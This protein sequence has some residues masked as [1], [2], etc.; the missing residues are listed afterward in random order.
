M[1]K[2]ILLACMFTLAVCG[3][4]GAG[5]KSV[6]A[7]GE[8]E[9]TLTF[10]AFNFRT[11]SYYTI[12]ADLKGAGD[13]FYVYVEHGWTVDPTDIQDIIN[14]FGII[15]TKLRD[16]YGEEKPDVN[17]DS[18]VYILLLDIQDD[19]NWPT[20]T[21]YTDGYFNP[22]DLY[23]NERY[24]NKRKVLYMDIH[25]GLYLTGFYSPK[26]PNPN[27]RNTMAHEFQHLIH[28]NI[29]PSD[30]TWLNEAMSEVASFYAFNEPRWNRVE[31]FQRNGNH[32][33]SLT[34]WDHELADYAVVYMW[35]QYMADRFPNDVFRNILAV[36]NLKGK[37]SVEE[38]LS[39]HSDPLGKKLEFASV[40]RDWSIAMF[41]GNNTSVFTDNAVW[42]YKSI[43][44]WPG[45]YN[46]VSIP[47]LFKSTNLNQAGFLSLDPWSIR[48]DWRNDTQTSSLRTRG[49]SSTLQASFYTPTGGLTFNMTPNTPYTYDD[50]IFLILQNTQDASYGAMP[51]NQPGPPTPSQASAASFRHYKTP[52][53]PTEKLSAFST[54][55]L[56][57]GSA[58]RPIPVCM[59]DI[60]SRQAEEEMLSD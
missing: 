30:D 37:D 55:E 11:S 40:F 36:K 25:P 7:V 12:N 14:N 20:M 26:S 45:S 24:S 17:G 22:V 8:S 16:S 48:Y 35:A 54:E 57:H 32:S 44:T 29:K 34:N 47:G 3:G 39:G 42:T 58:I 50:T 28:Y 33:N 23:A 4:E 59:R 6:K 52:P 15:Y 27:F 19:F 21:G 49:E 2:F 10:H 51:V 56:T 41:F 13:H 43:N 31:L 38:Y 5:V 53:T 1:K 9:S 46:G 60:L 18:K